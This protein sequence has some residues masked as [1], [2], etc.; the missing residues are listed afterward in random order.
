M[1]DYVDD[2]LGSVNAILA[3]IVDHS[4]TEQ[5]VDGTLPDEIFN[6][7]LAEDYWY[8]KQYSA[9]F[10]KI[11]E[12]EGS[13]LKGLG[14]ADYILKT[15]GWFR[16]E[17]L[18]KKGIKPFDYDIENENKISQFR[19]EKSNKTIVNY[20][21]HLR[22]VTEGGEFSLSVAIAACLPCFWVYVKIGQKYLGK[23]SPNS[24]YQQWMATYLDKEFVQME[25]R[26]EDAL[27]ESLLI[28]SGNG[29]W[30][31]FKK[32]IAFEKAFFTSVMESEK[33]LDMTP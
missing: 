4:F 22:K 6:I 14:F 8:I 26:L 20:I 13:P 2:L 15:E 10:K 1:G 7:Y 24:D 18:E 16:E 25:K 11:E 33:Q 17:I 23:E 32:S 12:R 9:I 29:V 31:A 5:M 21:R 28:D 19:P 27:R 3:E 30:D